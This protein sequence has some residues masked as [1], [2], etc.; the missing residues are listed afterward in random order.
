MEQPIDAYIKTYIMRTS[1]KRSRTIE[2]TVPRDV[3]VRQAR[4]VGL[5]ID[6]YLKQYRAVAHYNDFDGVYYRFEKHKGDKDGYK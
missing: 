1:G 2:V 4:R 5:S 6:E 3:I